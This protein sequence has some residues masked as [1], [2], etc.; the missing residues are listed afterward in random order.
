MPLFTP[1][2]A[3]AGNSTVGGTLGVT[4]VLTA[5][6]GVNSTGDVTIT[7]GNA[8]VATAGK[9]V[10]VKEGSNATMGTLAVNGA[11]PVVVSTTAVTANSRIFLTTNVAGGTPAFCYVSTRTA[12]TSFTVQGV[13]SDTSTVAWLIVEPSP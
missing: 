1:P 7:S 13:A 10:K 9:G 4:G 5:S 12:G 8:V 3:V 6:A 2:G 11:T